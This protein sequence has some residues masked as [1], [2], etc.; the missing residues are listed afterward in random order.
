MM[1]D[2][3]LFR[4]VHSSLFTEQVNDLILKTAKAIVNSFANKSNMF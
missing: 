4:T 1:P 3:K 2:L